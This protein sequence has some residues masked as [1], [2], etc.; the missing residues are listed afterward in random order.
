LEPDEAVAG[1]ELPTLAARGVAAES[2]T[3]LAQAEPSPNPPP[4]S[5]PPTV[6]E[7]PAQSTAEEIAL[8]DQRVLLRRGVTTVDIGVLLSRNERSLFPVVRVEQSTIGAGLALRYGLRDDFQVTMRMPAVRSR[9]STFTDATVSGTTLPATARE[10]YVGDVTVSLLRVAAREAAGRPNVVWSIDGVVPTGPGDSGVGGGVVL[11][12]SYDPAVIFAGFSYL[13][14]LS[15]DPASPRRALAKHNL[16]LNL[17]YT[18]AV[19]D[20]LALNTSL[21]GVYR[22]SSSGAGTA[23]PPP[24]ERYSLQFGM[25]WLLARGLVLEP[26]V[27]VGVGGDSPDLA[28]SLN[29][30]RSARRPRP[31]P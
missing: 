9:T 10:D 14:G 7:R 16:G 26:A 30:Q 12:K 15:V 21:L 6:G 13:Y 31:G 22:S 3:R 28:F 29:L 25:T 4:S 18:Y 20:S 8:R 17:G 27:E 19:N 2:P 24:T 1:E 5:P 11:S 23:I